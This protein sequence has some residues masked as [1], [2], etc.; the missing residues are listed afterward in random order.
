MADGCHGLRP[1]SWADLRSEA[2]AHFGN[3]LKVAGDFG[4]A[5]EAFR[6][7]DGF[8][9]QGTGNEAL[10]AQLL[11]FQASLRTRQSCFEEASQFLLLA[12][13]IHAASGDDDALAQA[14]VQLAIA[15]NEAGKPLEALRLVTRAAHLARGVSSRLALLCRHNGIVFL[16][17]LGRHSE[18]LAALARTTELYEVA[19]DQL[20]LFRRCWLKAQVCAAHGRRD[21][22][23]V[24]E[25]HFRCALAE[26]QELRLPYE[27]A[28]VGLELAE[29][30]AARGRGGEIASVVQAILPVFD[31]LGI[32]RES[33]AARLL[34]RSAREQQL[35]CELLARVVAV[36]ERKIARPAAS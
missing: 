32:G 29:L 2:W 7:S 22:D 10:R 13:E 12:C 17:A 5:E 23:E 3:A 16:A 31:A 27:A 26:A 30:L 20:L 14:L 25:A 4:R 9:R 15:T 19:G 35:A 34:R 24:A 18:A 33:V 8:W 11:Q 21:L 28:K 1:S 6:A 36:F